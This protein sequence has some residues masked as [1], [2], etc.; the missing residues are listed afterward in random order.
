MLAS[1]L[2][3]W[4]NLQ[5]LNLSHCKLQEKEAK[6]IVNNLRYC[7]KLTKLDLGYNDIVGYDAEEIRFSLQLHEFLTELV[8]DQLNIYLLMYYHY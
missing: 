8:L 6:V 4:P 1:C 5:E 7:T 2:Q 3:Y